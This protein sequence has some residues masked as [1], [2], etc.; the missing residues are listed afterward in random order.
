MADEVFKL[1]GSSY[2]EIAKIIRAYGHAHDEATLDD[3]ASRAAV[4][5]T[6]VSR[7]N[8]FLISLGILFGG[9]KKSLTP[10]GR[11]LSQALDHELIEKIQ[12][13]WRNLVEENEFLKK[14]VSAV[15]IRNGM[16]PSQLRAHIAYTAGVPKKPIAMTGSNAI[17]DI[18]RQ[19]GL[20]TERDG[21]II[22]ETLSI[23]SSKEMH[24]TSIAN[25]DLIG[26]S[27]VAL[28]SS[29]P[30]D[31]DRQRGGRHVSIQ[32]NV[33]CVAGD[34]PGLAKNIQDLLSAIQNTNDPSAD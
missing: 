22:A 13:A 1:P 24:L 31:E 19:S 10:E 27:A 8:G 21:K 15:R 12:E 14:I 29:E 3:V 2:A 17:I 6:F 9:K 32:I 25:S 11:E 7:N 20:L 28:R 33:N 34:L 5:K 26:V 4:D 23:S 30:A 16:D 18:L